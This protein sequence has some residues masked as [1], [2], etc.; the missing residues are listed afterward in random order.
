MVASDPCP[1]R[2]AVAV[3]DT[4]TQVGQNR[5]SFAGGSPRRVFVWCY[6]FGCIYTP[7]VYGVRQTVFYCLLDYCYYC[8]CYCYCLLLLLF[9]V[10]VIIIV[11]VIASHTAFCHHRYRK[12]S[13]K[14]LAAPCFRVDLAKGGSSDVDMS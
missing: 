10:I 9:I 1:D 12:S 13:F 8:Y 5:Q 11:I 2:T 4:C 6:V 3:T 14:N 7:G